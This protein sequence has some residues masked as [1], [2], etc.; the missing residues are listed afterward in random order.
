[1]SK[2]A[3][4]PRL[5]VTRDRTAERF[6]LRRHQIGVEDELLSF[7]QYSIDGH[8]I[9]VSH[10]ETLV[11]HRNNDFA[12]MLMS[13]LLDDI[14][15]WGLRVRPT[16]VVAASYINDHPEMHYLLAS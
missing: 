14:R 8:V 2:V 3:Y 6:E 1:M 15:M 4:T 13:G 11:Q 5:I 7:A 9:T 12:T 16:C 10:V